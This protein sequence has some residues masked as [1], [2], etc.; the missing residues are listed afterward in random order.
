MERSA[1]LEHPVLYDLRR[2]LNRRH[3]R[4]GLPGVERLCSFVVNPQELNPTTKVK[5]GT[6]KNRPDRFRALSAF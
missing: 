3:P 5:K 4:T 2:P 6:K 1:P